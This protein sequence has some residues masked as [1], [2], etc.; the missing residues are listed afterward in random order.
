[1][2]RPSRCLFQELS[3]CRSKKSL[4]QQLESVISQC[5]CIFKLYFHT[6]VHILLTWHLGTNKSQ[7]RI[8]LFVSS[9]LMMSLISNSCKSFGTSR[10]L[11]T[12]KQLFFAFYIVI[13]QVSKLTTVVLQV[14][15]FT[16]VILQVPKFTT[17]ILQVPKKCVI[18][19]VGF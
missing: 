5:W 19:Q 6:A 12:I 13:L 10:S 9:I 18:L 14:P 11:Y 2:C 1:M 4:I 16:T 17:V 15:K 8:L 7:L 3:Y